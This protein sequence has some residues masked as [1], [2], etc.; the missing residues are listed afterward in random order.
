MR[1]VDAIINKLMAWQWICSGCNGRDYNFFYVALIVVP[2]WVML[3]TIKHTGFIDRLRIS[4][5]LQNATVFFYALFAFYCGSRSPCWPAFIIQLIDTWCTAR[6]RNDTAPLSRLRSHSLQTNACLYCGKASFMRYH[7]ASQTSQ[8]YLWA[9]V[10]W[11]VFAF[12]HFCK[13]W[14][15]KANPSHP[16]SISLFD[17]CFCIC[18]SPEVKH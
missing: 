13:V 4:Q 16:F 10:L 14:K 2:H 6:S 9:R 7:T 1:W 15:R 18:L 11:V 8:C 5:L 12:V 3:A 17:F